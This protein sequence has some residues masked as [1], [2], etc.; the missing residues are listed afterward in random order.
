MES[1][2]I[3]RSLNLPITSV[4][5][6]NASA[7]EEVQAR[8][9]EAAKVT[10]PPPSGDSAPHGGTSGQPG[11]GEKVDVYDTESA[12]LA[13]EKSAQASIQAQTKDD[14][15]KAEEQRIQKQKILGEAEKSIEAA[16]APVESK[17]PFL[18]PLGDK[19]STPTQSPPGQSFDATA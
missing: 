6:S 18:F 3:T 4:V 17:F 9:L 11:L 8:T 10:A 13:A 16:Q 7:A 5:V 12:K 19:V 14:L 2:P 15:K 1:S